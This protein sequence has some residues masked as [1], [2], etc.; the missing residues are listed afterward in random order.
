MMKKY[1]K[2]SPNPSFIHL[3]SPNFSYESHTKWGSN[4]CR[5]LLGAH[6]KI[7]PEVCGTVGF[8]G[9]DKFLIS[10]F[11][12]KNTNSEKIFSKILYEF[13]KI[14][15]FNKKFQATLTI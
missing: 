12:K 7:P 8:E 5:A 13:S 2:P 14:L 4:H 3:S 10:L 1:V 15:I 9:G 6:D 11:L